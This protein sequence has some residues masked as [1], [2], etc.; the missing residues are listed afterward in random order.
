MSNIAPVNPKSPATG[1]PTQSPIFKATKRKPSSPLQNT[2]GDDK[3]K[4]SKRID[5]KKKKVKWKNVIGGI[6]LLMLV[7]GGGA[8]Y[9]L[10]QQSQDIRQQ[11]SEGVYY[12]CLNDAGDSVNCDTIGKSRCDCG[13]YWTIV[14]G[15]SCSGACPGG[16]GGDDDG[17]GGGGGGDDDG[18]GGDTCNE[19]C[20]GPDGILYNC[21]PPEA[22]GTSEDSICNAAGRVESC[23][24]SEYCCP[25]AGGAW[26]TDMTACTVDPSPS[27][28][29]TP[30]VS[31]SPSPTP[32]VSPSPSP[33]PEV[34]P[35]PSPTP[36]VSP[37]PSPTPTTEP[38]VTYSCNSNC[39]SNAQCQSAN[40]S[41]ICYL[42]KCRLDS[43]PTSD[44]CTQSSSTTTQ[45]E[46]PAELPESG[47]EDI[48]NW[49]KAGLGVLGIGTVLLLL[50]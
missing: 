8:G 40:S 21:T 44:Q 22:D 32:E 47:S 19:Q 34:S 13:D 48:L 3:K 17:G 4:T 27:P 29:P 39:S 18:G 20:P 49:F 9:W 23:G 42:S 25:E 33:T 35:S 6:I 5:L 30:E 15:D 2:G 7:I 43:N 41:Y 46:L 38:T 11:A 24:G 12:D 26:T 31:P 45:P 50:L 28:S 14:D 1:S 16:G 37:S 10:T 36:E